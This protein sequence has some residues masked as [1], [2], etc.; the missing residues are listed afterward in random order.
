MKTPPR[1]SKP[2]EGFKESDVF[3]LPES[4]WT[5]EQR[6]RMSSSIVGNL[7][8]RSMTGQRVSQARA[9]QTSG[10]RRI[11]E[12]RERLQRQ[13]DPI[14]RRIT[15]LS[16]SQENWRNILQTGFTR[17][18]SKRIRVDANARRRVEESLQ[19]SEQ[20]LP[21]LKERLRQLKLEYKVTTSFY[22]TLP[23][24]PPKPPPGGS[25][26]GVGLSVGPW[27]R[28]P[29]FGRPNYV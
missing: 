21:Q 28:R 24:G 22:P 9:Q 3:R 19:K 5:A 27:P 6:R 8:R 26:G 7:S 12:Q 1:P 4:E 15:L 18:G 2:N 23:K 16:E 10:Y 20:D 17:V 13:I 14:Q 25:G 29:Q 11:V